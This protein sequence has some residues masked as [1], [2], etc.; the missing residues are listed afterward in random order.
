MPIKNDFPLRTD[1]DLTTLKSEPI[2]VN[3]IKLLR[4]QKTFDTAVY[5]DTVDLEGIIDW[6]EHPAVLDNKE[7]NQLWSFGECIDPL[8]GHQKSNI[9]SKS[10]FFMVDYDN[11]YTIEQFE[12]DYKDYFYMLY[13]SFSHT[14]E[15][16]K[17]RVI[18]F[19]NY[20]KP[21]DKD[22][23]T[24]ILSECFRNADVSTFQ[25]NRMFYIPAHKEGAPYYY[26]LHNG[27][28]FPLDN[29]VTRLLKVQLLAS[30][31]KEAQ[32]DKEWKDYNSK[33]DHNGMC[34]N[35]TT[36]KKYLETPYPYING[37]G[38]SDN[39]L[40]KAL[41]TCIKYDDN[42]TL[43]DVIYKAKSEHWTDCEIERKIEA[44]K[45]NYL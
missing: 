5:Q 23:Q 15:H 41:R 22:E 40:F 21:L 12:K 30:R 28:Q 3:N 20:E 27:K 25:P 33:T 37:N 31:A 4:C 34:I 38:T 44:I 17:F 35:Y 43:Q 10:K 36:V 42:Q 39:D 16:N 11:G 45:E 18:M 8:K 32:Q 2:Q 9:K 26:K 1:M 7:D 6:I 19:G 14:K 13:T 24:I 29:S